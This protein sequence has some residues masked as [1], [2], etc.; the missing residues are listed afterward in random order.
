MITQREKYHT[1]FCLLCLL[2]S[3][4]N[5]LCCLDTKFTAAYSSNAANTKRRHTAIQMSIAFTYETYK[6]KEIKRMEIK[7]PVM[8]DDMRWRQKKQIS[9]NR[10]LEYL[11]GITHNHFPIHFKGWPE[12]SKPIKVVSWLFVWQPF[13][14]GGLFT[15]Q[16]LLLFHLPSPWSHLHTLPLNE[17]IILF[18][19]IMMFLTITYIYSVCM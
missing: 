6:T 10:N 9:R 7:T 16:V 12:N 1:L 17:N 15:L 2:R 14:P 11:S 3:L 13:G 19:T 8:R 5:S 18:L 4:R